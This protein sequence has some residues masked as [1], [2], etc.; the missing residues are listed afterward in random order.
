MRKRYGTTFVR[1]LGLMDQYSA[2]DDYR[3]M[4][5]PSTSVAPDAV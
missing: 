5:E 3:G 1:R 4:R 2:Q